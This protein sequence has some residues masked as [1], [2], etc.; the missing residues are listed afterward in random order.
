MPKRFPTKYGL[1]LSDERGDIEGF[2]E[3][4][5][6]NQVFSDLVN[7]GIYFIRPSV[8][9]EI[10]ED[11]AFDFAKDLFPKLM[12]GGRRLAVY[13][14]AGYWCDIG[15]TEAYLQCVFD[16]LNGDVK[17]DL[18]AER[19]KEGVYAASELPK[20]VKISPPCYIGGM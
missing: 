20:G 9:D 11:T 18:P 19:V 8:L 3:K 10:P 1:V 2:L 12:K 6:W 14:A 15:D 7:T 16:A 4:P 17:L 5:S 13:Q